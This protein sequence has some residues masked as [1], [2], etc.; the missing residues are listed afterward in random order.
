MKR[1][2]LSV[3][4][5]I[6]LCVESA[7]ILRG[8]GS[9]F[10]G[11]LYAKWSDGF[12]AETNNSIEFGAVGSGEGVRRME[13]GSVDFGASDEPLTPAELEEKGLRQY[14]V[15]MGGIVPVVNLPGIGSGKLKLNA[16]VLGKIY[17]GHI[18]RWRDPAILSINPELA[19]IMPDLP[20]TPVRRNESSGS[21]FVFSYYLNALSPEW[22]AGPGAGKQLRGVAGVAA[23]GPKGVVGLL[24][25]KAGAIAYI[26]FLRAQQ[27]SLSMAQLPG[28]FG[29]Y[30]SPSP[31]SIR[32]AAR[33]VAEKSVFGRNQDFYMILTNSGT[34]DGWPMAMATFV[35][36][37]AKRSD[38]VMRTL[39]FLSWSFKHGDGAANELGY[40]P[41]PDLLKVGVRR[42]WSHTYGFKMAS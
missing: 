10:A 42:A 3:L 33:F 41:L 29:Y 36:L 12:R 30:M 31:D 35:V 1:L 7:S 28:H 4:S 22:R 40:V 21:T 39:E 17:L 11:P 13:A 32:A 26:D 18:Q 27:A 34:Y 15:A 16:D 9:T 37:P 23:D 19:A 8:A 5:L 24:K 6:C 20:I 25:S 14:P 2:A 38:S